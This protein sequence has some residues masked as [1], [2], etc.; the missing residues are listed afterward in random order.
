MRT[1]IALPGHQ[2]IPFE[3]PSELVG[4]DAHDGIGGLVEVL[5]PAEDLGGHGIA[6]DFVGPSGQG[7]IRDER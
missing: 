4:L 7:G 2:V 3:G 6:L 1:G 5:A